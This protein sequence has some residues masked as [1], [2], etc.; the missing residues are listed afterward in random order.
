MKRF[1]DATQGGLMHFYNTYY[2]HVKNILRILVKFSVNVSLIRMIR[3]SIIL[4][5]LIFTIQIKCCDHRTFLKL[6][7]NTTSFINFG[8]NNNKTVCSGDIQM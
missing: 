5:F 3:L 8:S 6:L 7:Y 4:F 2:Y 1:F